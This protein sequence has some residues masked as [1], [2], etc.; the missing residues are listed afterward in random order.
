MSESETTTKRVVVHGGANHLLAGPLPPRI[1]HYVLTFQSLGIP[2][3]RQMVR[4]FFTATG[5]TQQSIK[6]TL[7]RLLAGGQLSTLNAKLVVP[8]ASLPDPAHYG[9]AVKLLYKQL[10]AHRPADGPQFKPQFERALFEHR[11]QVVH[12]A[13]RDLDLMVTQE[14]YLWAR[15][16]GLFERAHQWNE[17]IPAMVPDSVVARFQGAWEVSPEGARLYLVGFACSLAAQQ[18]ARIANPGGYITS[19]VRHLADNMYMTRLSELDLTG[20]RPVRVWAQE[21]EWLT[22]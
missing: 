8:I 3:S 18:G 4:A 16:V 19:I 14:T 15:S 11:A 9:H 13:W 21:D 20:V 6:R 7:S 1:Y 22:D 5:S 17:T 12:A 10:N 2:V